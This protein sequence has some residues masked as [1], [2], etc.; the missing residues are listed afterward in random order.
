M[1]VRDFDEFAAER[2][3]GPECVPMDR[4]LSA[5]S[6]WNPAE[7][8]LLLCR[9]GTRATQAARQLE[10]V[11][12]G[13]VSVVEGGITACRAEGVAVVRPRKVI[14]LQRQV[15]MAA[16]VVLLTGLVLSLVNPWFIAV[17]WF[18]ASMLVMAGVTGFCPMA[19]ILG[20]MPW[21][22]AASCAATGA[23]CRKG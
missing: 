5:A 7:D 10:Q 1:D 14:P 18:A 12:F 16:G 19:K 20:R 2:I 4:L 8:V 11:G 3:E 17:D 6:R 22:A 21:N 13:K 9:S 15:L 23:T